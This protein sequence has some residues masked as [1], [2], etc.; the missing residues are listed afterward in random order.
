MAQLQWLRR[1]WS[2]NGRCV[3][4]PLRTCCSRRPW[5]SLPRLPIHYVHTEADLER[6]PAPVSEALFQ[7]IQSV[8]AVGSAQVLSGR[9]GARSAG[10]AADRRL[11]ILDGQWAF[12]VQIAALAGVQQRAD[13]QLRP[14]VRRPGSLLISLRRLGVVA[15]SAQGVAETEISQLQARRV[16]V[17][18][19]PVGG[20]NP[21]IGVHSG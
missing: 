1:S 3:A 5:S 13:L 21:P 9:I 18:G 8:S 10:A 19:L 16:E 15:L 20:Q 14:H 6:F 4:A 12:S 11:I 7:S 2:R 17:A